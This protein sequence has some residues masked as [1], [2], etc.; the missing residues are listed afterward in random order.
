MAALLAAHPWTSDSPGE[1]VNVIATAYLRASM[2]YQPES[3]PSDTGWMA[4]LASRIGD[5]SPG[6]LSKWHS[7]Q[8]SILNVLRQVD[9]AALVGQP[10][11]ITYGILR[12]SLESDIGTR[13]C[14]QELWGVNS[15]VNGWQ[16]GYSDVFGQQRIGNNVR[17]QAALARAR[18][19]PRFIDNEIANLREGVRLR[20]TSPAIIVQNVIRQM[21]D[22][23][24]GAPETS[25][26]YSPAERGTASDPPPAA[27]RHGPLPIRSRAWTAGPDEVAGAL[28]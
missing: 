3:A 21:D 19:L 26:F 11:W 13:I 12:G 27:F 14:R 24:A 4:P 9:A 7:Y 8:D 20:Y 6:A 18:A 2:E 16:N 23:S 5:N 10:E 17:R 15:Y 28:R 22:L 1:Q 25:P